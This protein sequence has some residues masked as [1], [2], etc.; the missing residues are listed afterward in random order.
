[1]F[2]VC[3]RWA[4]PQDGPD[5]KDQARVCQSSLEVVLSTLNF[6][7]PTTIDAVL[8]MNLAVRCEFPAQYATLPTHDAVVQLSNYLGFILSP[9]RQNI[10]LLDIH[11]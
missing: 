3:A 1:M 7:L 10:R 9:E 5:L 6:W 4:S 8:A 11:Q 2:T